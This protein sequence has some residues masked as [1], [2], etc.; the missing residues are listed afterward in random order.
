MGRAGNGPRVIHY[1]VI[2]IEGWEALDLPNRPSA[3][4]LAAALAA[5]QPLLQL[6]FH[7]VV[8]AWRYMPNAVAR[9]GQAIRVALREHAKNQMHSILS[10]CSLVSARERCR[11]RFRIIR[12][13]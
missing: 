12:A 9:V 2:A 5:A 6:G 13:R 3:R 10:A 4:L 7:L 8:L 11:E 1:Q